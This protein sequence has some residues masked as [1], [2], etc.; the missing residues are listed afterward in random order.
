MRK[1]LLVA[2]WKAN[3]DKNQ[4][5]EWFTRIAHNL[6]HL[7]ITENIEVIISPSF[8]FLDLSKQLISKHNLPFKLS[9]QDVSKFEQGSF[10]GEVTASQISTFVEY[11]IIGHSERRRYFKEN[12]EDLK[13]KI[14]L[15][16]DNSLK[17][18]YCTTEKEENIKEAEIIAFEP[19]YAIG[20]GQ[21]AP[22]EEVIRKRE[23][24]KLNENQKFLYGGSVNPTN[25]KKY[26]KNPLIDGVLVG[27]ASLNPDTFYEL[28][29]A[30][31]DCQANQSF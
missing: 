24:F 15:A 22:I 25:I 7:Q 3:K 6:K 10:T 28:I 30:A 17:V 14:K 11:A 4:V 21:N 18:I 20:T 19:T 5:A 12:E 2:N 31:I 8:P 16:K 13:R 1:K 9:S 26:L 27:S 23:E 29:K